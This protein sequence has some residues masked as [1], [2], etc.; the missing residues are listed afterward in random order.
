MARIPKSLQ[1]MPY[2]Q[3]DFERVSETPMPCS[4]PDLKQRGLSKAMKRSFYCT[5]KNSLKI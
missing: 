2:A 1:M 5:K 3:T 4:K